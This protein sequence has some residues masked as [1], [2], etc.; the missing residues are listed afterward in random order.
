MQPSA[1]MR[2]AGHCPILIHFCRL[3]PESVPVRG[4]L[5]S[6]FGRA[7]VWPRNRTQARSEIDPSRSPLRALAAVTCP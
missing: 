6:T 2:P 1:H 5:L 4:R 7:A 3:A